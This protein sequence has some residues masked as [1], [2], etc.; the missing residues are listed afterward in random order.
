LREHKKNSLYFHKDFINFSNKFKNFPEKSRK[1]KDAKNLLIKKFS[2]KKIVQESYMK[3]SVFSKK[4]FD[5]T[6]KPKVVI[7]L[8][9]FLDSPLSFGKVLFNDF[10]EWTNE[11]LNF[12]RK[13]NLNKEVFIKPHP[14]SIKESWKVEHDLKLKYSEFTWLKKDISNKHI[15]NLKPLF[16]LSVY[17]TV[18][19][20]MSYYNI[21][22]ICCGDNPTMSYNFVYY[23]KNKARY[24]KLI[25]LGINSKLKIQSKKRKIY[26]MTYCNYLH[27]ETKLDLL[28]KKNNFKHYYDGYKAF[29][30]IKRLVK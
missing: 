5:I 24:F 19:Q 17:G 25:Q 4:K 9:D 7:F 28:I 15:F 30:E 13:N 29:S 10:Y 20:E 22:S 14:N 26:E 3:N 27:D 2:G 18:L 1:I 23:P 11:T 21:P 8:H 16:G 6:I 12:L